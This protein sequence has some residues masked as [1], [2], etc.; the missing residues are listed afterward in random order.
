MNIVFLIRAIGSGGG[1]ELQMTVLAKGL[2]S[3]GH[4]VTVIVLYGEGS[5]FEVELVKA[6]IHIID[7]KKKGFWD[8]FGFLYRYDQTLKSI[9]PDLLHGYMPM[10]NLLVL[11]SQL[12]LPRTKVVW[13]LRASNI[14][15]GNIPLSTQVFFKLS[16]WLSDKADLIISNSESGKLFHIN[17]GYPANLIEIIPNGIDADYFQ[18]DEEG[19]QLLRHQ[20]DV[21]DAQLLIGN[22]ARLDRIKDHSTF[23]HACAILRQEYPHIKIVCAGEDSAKYRTELELL[24]KELLLQDLLIWAGLCGGMNQVYSA[25]DLEV[26]SSLYEGFPNAVAEAMSCSVPVVSTNVGDAKLMLEGI[27][28][29]VPPGDP[30]ALA[31]AMSAMLKKNLSD[32]GYRGRERIV[33]R[34]SVDNLVHR[35][36]TALKALLDKE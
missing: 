22:V 25:L 20:W 32:V 11:L 6:G 12:F 26:C 14:G 36:E 9:R 31:K 19:R 3:R 28:S 30:T 33:E 24:A 7:L 10:Q 35:T 2:K 23:L 8:V 16:C 5:D 27:G 15:F 4:Q 29:C 34:Y 21:S 1:A 18:R 13:G 17:K